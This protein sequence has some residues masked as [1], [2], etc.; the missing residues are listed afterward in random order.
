M[1][2]EA[3]AQAP[4]SSSMP[5]DEAALE[6]DFRL[7]SIWPGEAEQNAPSF[8][9]RMALYLWDGPL[10]QRLSVQA[11]GDYRG[12]GSKALPDDGFADP[13]RATRSIFALGAALGY[14]VVRTPRFVVDVR[15]GVMFMREATSIET[16]VRAGSSLS[17]DVW[18]TVCHFEGFRA[19][20]QSD[21]DVPATIAIGARRYFGAFG[22][23]YA[24]VDY[25]RVL[26]G[27]NILVGS[28]GLRL[29]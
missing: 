15:G 8:G 13:L 22:D 23:Y 12:L 27:R 1:V 20:C 2:A 19:D 29:R 21:R 3:H 7:G 9:G 16:R 18:E 14:D 26:D 5:G 4:G 24:G 28:F 17:D 6:L 25:T 11:T 10:A